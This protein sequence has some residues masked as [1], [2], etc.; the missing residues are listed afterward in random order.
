MDPV[1]RRNFWQPFDPLKP[2]TLPNLEH[3]RLDFSGYIEALRKTNRLKPSLH[4]N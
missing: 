1:I 2:E 3:Y 4:L